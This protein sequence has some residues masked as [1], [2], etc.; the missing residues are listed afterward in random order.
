[1]RNSCAS[2][3]NSKR[4]LRLR[5]REQ[6]KLQWRKLKA[7]FGKKH[8]RSISAVE[9]LVNGN[10]IRTS[11]K[12]I[13]EEAIV[14]ENDVPFS[15]AYSS[16]MFQ[17]SILEKIGSFGQESE[18]HD[19]IHNNIR[20]STDNDQV[21]QF[22]PLLCQPNCKPIQAHA[23]TERWNDHW[24]SSKEKTASSFSGLHFRCHEA[25]VMSKIISQIKAKLMSISISNGKPL[26]RWMSGASIML[27]KKLNELLV[28]KLRA[29]LLLEADF[30]AANKIIFNTRLIH[31]LESKSEIPREIVVGRRE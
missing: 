22:L 9:R 27:E 24:R 16:P 11:E 26:A 21:N 18:S 5:R 15:L 10:L 2:S 29:M 17:K 14:K 8:M 20:I 28:S 25:Q 31:T 3:S 6:E 12:I 19:L 30:N 1:M 13:V 7:V 23:S 4:L